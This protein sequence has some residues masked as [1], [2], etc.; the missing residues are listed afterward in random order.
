[1]LNDSIAMLTP[2]WRLIKIEGVFIFKWN[3]EKKCSLN[4]FFQTDFR[5]FAGKMTLFESGFSIQLEKTYDIVL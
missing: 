2:P 5:F 4:F 3:S 1:M